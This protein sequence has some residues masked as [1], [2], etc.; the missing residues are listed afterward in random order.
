MG[1]QADICACALAT[2]ITDAETLCMIL[3]T[4]GI[5]EAIGPQIISDPN[6]FMTSLYPIEGFSLHTEGSTTSASNLQWF[7][8]NFMGEEKTAMEAEGKNVYDAC[9]VAKAKGIKIIA[10]TGK[11]G[12]TLKTI[13][14][15]SIVTPCNETYQIQE[16]HLPIYHCLCLMLE[17]H[18]FG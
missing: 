15:I 18:F 10:L 1:G 7:V 4:W 14:D 2:G 13:A 12:G 11:T 6:F 8:D 3:G 9:V 5:N 16:L 17:E